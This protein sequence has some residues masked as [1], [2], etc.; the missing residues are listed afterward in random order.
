MTRP[1]MLGWL[2][3]SVYISSGNSQLEPVDGCQLSDLLDV[4][5]ERE[6]GNDDNVN[7]GDGTPVTVD[8]DDRNAVCQAVGRRRD[9]YRFRSELITFTGRS[10][11]PTVPQVALVDFM[12]VDAGSG[13]VE[14]QIDGFRYITNNEEAAQL[15]SSPLISNCSSCSGTAPSD[16]NPICTGKYVYT[17]HSNHYNYII[18]VCDS[19]CLIEEQFLCYGNDQ[20]TCCNVYIDDVC[21]NNCPIN[22]V[23]AAVDF[24][25]GESTN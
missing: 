4:D 24:E 3:L 20:N 11:Q 17:A 18:I 7:S 1:L 8:V 22:Q 19:D 6:L 21:A 10:S 16:E 15:Q 2:L 12:C 23:P 25:C 13:L 9:R 14:W 5:V